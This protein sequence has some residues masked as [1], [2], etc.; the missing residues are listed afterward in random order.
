[1]THRFYLH[2]FVYPWV[3]TISITYTYLQVTGFQGGNY[4]SSLAD[5]SLHPKSLCKGQMGYGAGHT[6]TCNK[7]QPKT[8][9]FPLQ[10]ASYSALSMAVWIF[11][12]L[13]PH[14]S[15]PNWSD[16]SQL[17]PRSCPCT[18][19]SHFFAYNE[20]KCGVL[21]MK[22]PHK[23]QKILVL[24]FLKKHLKKKEQK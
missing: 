14:I 18:A 2:I 12:C 23:V 17:P 5:C 11:P 1:M 19:A 9:I 10:L 13:R 22:N 4:F 8:H 21:R 7:P 20:Q 15:F 6:H 24:I 16:T 3:A